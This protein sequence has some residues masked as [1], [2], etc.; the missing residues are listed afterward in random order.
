M[1]DGDPENPD[2]RGYGEKRQREALAVLVRACFFPHEE[3]EALN[4]DEPW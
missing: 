2:R 1:R 3:L 4:L